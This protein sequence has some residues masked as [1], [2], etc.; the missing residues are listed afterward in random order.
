M[1][2]DKIIDIL[3]KRINKPFK[4]AFLPYKRE[5]WDSLES[6]YH[7]AIARGIE[8][9][10]VPIPYYVLDINR[11]I[12]EIK[13][14]LNYDEPI[15]SYK[16]FYDLQGVDYCFIHN[17]YD[18]ENIVTQI[19][20][21][22]QTDILKQKGK[23]IIYIPYYVKISNSH[24]DTELINHS[25]VKNSDFIFLNTH[26]EYTDF[27]KLVGKHNNI[28][29]TGSPKLDAMQK[30]K[31]VQS[32]H[33]V[34]LNNSLVPFIKNP[35]KKI[36]QYKL[37]I[38]YC[39]NEGK[40]VIFR[41]HPLLEDGIQSVCSEK[42]FTLY[43]EFLNWVRKVAFIDDNADVQKTIS[44]CDFMYSDTSSVIYLWTI[45]GKPFKRI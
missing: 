13:I 27:T 15:F 31:N 29:V 26:T 17:P 4:L 18:T 16:D 41:P 9:Y 30:Y 32:L 7:C 38:E 33:Y 1:I 2:A 14:D 35:I 19:A 5:M 22:F 12:R 21:E 3:I 36:E 25:G 28:F 8:S 39:L 6:V 44:I 24:T 34:L 20:P 42:A 45:T 10:L 23:K 40:Q 43:Q 37:I 11:N